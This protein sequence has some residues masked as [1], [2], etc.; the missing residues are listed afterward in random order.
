MNKYKWILEDFKWLGRRAVH[1]VTGKYPI[2]LERFA[3]RGMIDEAAANDLFYKG[4]SG[5]EPF[6]IGRTGF[7]EIGF[8]CCAQSEIYYN[9]RIHY[10]WTPSYIYGIEQFKEGELQAYYHVLRD[11]M[12]EMDA[13]GTYPAMFM[14]DAV[15]STLKN[16][17]DIEI[18]NMYIFDDIGKFEVPWTK[19]L[20]GKKVLVVSPFYR[21]I[22]TQYERRDLLWPDGRLPEC[23]MDYDPSL[24]IR[25]NGGFFESLKI[26]KERVLAKDFDI[27]LLGCGSL[28]VPIA[29]EIKKAGKKAVVMGSALH[30]LYG[31]KGKR[32]DDR[33][34]YNEYWIR[35]GEYTK[36]S[37][38]DKID[39]GTYW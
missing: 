37:Y 20:K 22:M 36:P 6:A 31:I 26:L 15:L 12:D 14:S 19:A 34:I 16:I 38:A 27:A 18:Y 13:M 28:G 8:M 23:E 4:L 5:S 24:W 11:A 33:G 17:K 3:G 9:S 35:P 25:E 29:A 7:G 10:H 30:L 1:A 21:E 39:S 32:W 2:N